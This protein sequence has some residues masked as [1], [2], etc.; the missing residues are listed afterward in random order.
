MKKSQS[1]FKGINFLGLGAHKGGTSWIHAC[2][3]DHPQ[4]FMPPDKELH[5]FSSNYLKGDNWYKK[6]F[7]GSTEGQ[8]C[9]EISPT[10][11]PSEIAPKR[12]YDFK[13]DIKLLVCLRNPVD[14][15]FSAYK[16]AL[17]IGQIKP[18]RSFESALKNCGPAFLQYGL[19]GAQLKNYLNYFSKN[20]LLVMLYEDIRKDPETFIRKIY[21]FLEVD[22]HFKS[23]FVDRKIN[24]SKGVPRITYINKFMSTTATIL[25]SM[26]L[27]NLVWH[28][29][30]SSIAE[31][32][33]HLNLIEF[34]SKRSFHIS[35][36]LTDELQKFYRND[37]IQLSELL[38][39]DLW[40]IWMDTT[41][42]FTQHI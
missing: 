38:G 17:Q 8:I 5:Y 20:Q 29:G 14:R 31:K 32:I 26:H 9:G 36:Q 19:Y 13:K 21:Y 33:Q 1:Q 6:Q 24:T 39:V 35:P 41:P 42:N 23:S 27:G 15:A 22:P 37:V 11:L 3:Y 10:Y 18:S 40:K 25:R 2:L 34:N 7:I 30:R 12:I 28:I 4:I 16:Y